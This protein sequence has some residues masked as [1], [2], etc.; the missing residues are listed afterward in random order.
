MGAGW[1]RECDLSRV[2]MVSGFGQPR[3]V[4]W[5]DAGGGFEEG[6]LPLPAIP[7]EPEYFG[8]LGPVPMSDASTEKCQLACPVDAPGSAG[9]GGLPNRQRYSLSTSGLSGL[10]LAT[11]R[12]TSC[13]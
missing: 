6:A 2:G 7:D 12:F 3:F 13:Q 8:I 4:T 5:P 1:G 9:M 10:P 11:A